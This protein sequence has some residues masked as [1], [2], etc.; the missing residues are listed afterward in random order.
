MTK[1][2]SRRAR[3]PRIDP[4]AKVA[5]TVTT[6]EQARHGLALADISNHTDAD[7]REMVRLR[8]AEPDRDTREHK[9]DKA[10]QTVRKLTRVEKLRNA[11]VITPEQALACEWYGERFELAFDSGQGTTANYGG[12]GGRGGAGWDHSA[13]S[14]AQAEARADVVYAE[15]AIPKHLLELFQFVVVGAWNATP[16][17]T[18]EDKLRFSLAAHRLHGQVAHL[19]MVA[20]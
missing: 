10:R 19:L 20:A 2:K 1:G 9:S 17:L 11:G 6:P 12:V 13:R 5:L 4:V 8:A 16:R 18:K 15:L 14:S 3:K 7:Q